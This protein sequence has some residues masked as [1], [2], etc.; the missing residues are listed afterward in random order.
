MRL[1]E[2]ARQLVV[3]CS[4]LCADIDVGPAVRVVPSRHQQLTTH[5][6]EVSRLL[7]APRV[8]EETQRTWSEQPRSTFEA[9]V[10]VID[11]VGVRGRHQQWR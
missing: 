6:H 10:L 5:P 9:L 2:T 8:E 7:C 1:A 4:E 3:V 11:I